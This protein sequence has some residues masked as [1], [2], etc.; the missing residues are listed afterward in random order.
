MSLTTFT[1]V[2]TYDITFDNSALM[3]AAKRVWSGIKGVSFRDTNYFIS[4]SP[5]CFGLKLSSSLLNTFPGGLIMRKKLNRNRMDTLMLTNQLNI[6]CFSYT[7]TFFLEI[8]SLSSNFLFTMGSLPSK[9]VRMNLFYYF[10]L[11][12]V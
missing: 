2:L 6:L 10:P 11:V 12:M 9:G 7:C 4:F 5:T 3:K 8:F 1:I